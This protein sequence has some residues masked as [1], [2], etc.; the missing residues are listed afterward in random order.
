MRQKLKT[1]W[2]IGIMLL[3]GSMVRSQI[4]VE[5][6]FGDKKVS[7]DLM[8]FKYFKK[9]VGKNSPFLF[10][11]RNRALNDYGMTG[12]SHLPQF[13]FTEAIS[14]N[15]KKWK[16][17]APV[18]VT[19][20]SNRGVYP[21]A[22]LQYARVK[23]DFTLFSWTVVETRKDPGIDVFFLGRYTP[24][25]SKTLHGFFQGELI[26]VLPTIKRNNFS[27]SQRVRIGLKI[28]PFQFGFA[29]D[30]TQ[31]GRAVYTTTSNVGGFLRYEF[32]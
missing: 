13:G 8:F 23:K 20:L 3:S 7:I 2:A 9:S 14:Y 30:L 32:Q 12:D 19:I 24:L 4:P 16:G 15:P 29:A 17:L 5:L 10:F 25:L 31:T 1:I 18:W 26:Q 22:G 27:F 28:K 6:A 21:K 11:H